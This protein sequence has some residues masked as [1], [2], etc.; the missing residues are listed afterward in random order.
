MRSGLL[1]NFSLTSLQTDQSSLPQRLRL[2]GELSWPAA[3]VSYP[4]G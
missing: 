1:C 3:L 2:S 4:Q